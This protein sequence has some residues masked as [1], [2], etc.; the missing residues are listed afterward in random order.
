MS[1]ASRGCPR[2][3][4]PSKNRPRGRILAPPESRHS[5]RCCSGR[6]P[7]RAL[8][9]RGRGR[10]RG[11]QTQGSPGDRRCP[12]APTGSRWLRAPLRPEARTSADAARRGLIRLRAPTAAHSSFAPTGSWLPLLESLQVETGQVQGERHR[13][14]ISHVQLRRVAEHQLAHAE[15]Y[16][17]VDGDP[18]AVHPERVVEVAH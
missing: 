6:T 3:S 17:G 4:G 10:T 9:I 7:E 1:G 15:S 12:R 5:S 18:V 13:Q 11:T 8:A 16:A 14:L 2:L